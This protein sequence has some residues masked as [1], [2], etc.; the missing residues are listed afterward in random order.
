MAISLKNAPGLGES[1]AAILAAL[2][3]RG[4]LTT[5]GLAAELGLNVETVRDHLRALAAHG[6]VRRAGAVRG[7]RGRPELVHAL[8]PAAEAFFPQREGEVLRQLAAY[9]RETGNERLLER[10]FER[11]IAARRE[12]ALARVTRLEGRERLEEAARILTELGFMAELEGPPD[13]PR[14]RLCHCP[15]REL[16]DETAIP[17]K[18]EIGFVSELLGDRLVRVS[19]IPAGDPSCSYSGAA[20]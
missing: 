11:V 13:E 6:L 1:Q 14:L 4:E 8:A 7:G 18:V 15:L 3:R 10:F 16:V 2:K 17:C 9:L 12:G 20:A 19:H 5:A